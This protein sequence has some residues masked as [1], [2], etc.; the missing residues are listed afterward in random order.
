[1]PFN[2]LKFEKKIWFY[3]IQVESHCM[4]ICMMWTFGGDVNLHTRCEM[5]IRLGFQGGELWRRHPHY[6]ERE[7]F[8]P[9][10]LAPICA[11]LS[12]KVR[13]CTACGFAGGAFFVRVR[14]RPVPAM[15]S[16]SPVPS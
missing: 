2:M 9:L 3:S 11:I 5:K 14:R 1:M 4:R 16:A 12:V 15:H 10:K 7:R 13:Q 6:F 8:P